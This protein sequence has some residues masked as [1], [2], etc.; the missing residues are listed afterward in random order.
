LGFFPKK[1]KTANPMFHCGSFLK[2]KKNTLEKSVVTAVV[3]HSRPQKKVEWSYST[4]F[5]KNLRPTKKVTRCSDALPNLRML[6]PKKVTF[7]TN[8]SKV[9]VPETDRKRKNNG[10]KCPFPCL[11]RPMVTQKTQ[12]PVRWKARV[13]AHQKMQKLR[14]F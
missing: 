6:G 14:F 1:K 11:P 7:S 10:K 3:R 4:F 5:W 13:N 12:H 8:I 9:F 2:K